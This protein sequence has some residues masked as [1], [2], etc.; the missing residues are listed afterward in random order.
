MNLIDKL[1]FLQTLFLL[2]DKHHTRVVEEKKVGSKP[3]ALI[4][5]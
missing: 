1:I 4:G 2:H 3:R 5:T